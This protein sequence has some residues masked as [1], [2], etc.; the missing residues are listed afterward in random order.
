LRK[1]QE[2]K[3]TVDQKPDEEMD[4]ARNNSD[5]SEERHQQHRQD[6][7]SPV[8][9]EQNVAEKQASPSPRKD[10]DD[11]LDDILNMKPGH[12]RENILRGVIKQD[13]PT[14]NSSPD[15]RTRQ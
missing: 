6:R 15:K 14:S 12:F 7:S 11:D 5:H 2:K 1:L 8:K 4:S 10:S 9:Q 13:K 3:D